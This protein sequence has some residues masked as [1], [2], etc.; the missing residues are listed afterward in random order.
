MR[1]CF[2]TFLEL[3]GKIYRNCC[4]VNKNF[5]L[6]LFVAFWMRSE[7]KARN[8]G[9]PTVGFCLTTM[10]Q[11]TGRYGQTFLSNNNVAKVNHPPYSPNLSSADFYLSFK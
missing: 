2:K 9:E 4:T 5:T 10:L 6:I 3:A 1:S 7:G 11:H 8:S